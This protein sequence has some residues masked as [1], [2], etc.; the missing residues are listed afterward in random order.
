MLALLLAA[1]ASQEVV[2]G[3]GRG[4]AVRLVVSGRIDLHYLVR[5]AEINEAGA[6][7]NGVPGPSEN[8]DA[9]TGRFT[10][11]ADAELK[12]RVLGVV[13]IENRSYDQG[14]NRPLGA[15]PETDEL[16][17]KQG[18]ID[19]PDFFLDGLRVRVGIQDVS[20]RNRPH[21]EPF[22]L[23]LGEVEGFYG[24]FSTAGARISNS[25]DRDVREAVGLSL[26]WTPYEIL[27]VL[28]FAVVVDENGT[29]TDD[30]IVYGLLASGR[31]AEHSALW[32]M[33]MVVSGGAPDLGRIWTLGSGWNTYAGAGR[34][35]EL[36]AEAYVQG[37]SLVDNVDKRAFAANVGARALFGP[38]WFE[39]AA[40]LRTGDHD[41][42]DARDEAFQSYENENRFLALQ[43]GEF[44]L[45][46]DT[47]LL[48]VRAAVGAGPFD[49]DRHPLRL[50]LDVGRFEADQPVVGGETDWGLEADLEASL[51]WNE[52]LAFRLKLAWLGAS[53]LLERLTADGDDAALLFLA[54]ADLRF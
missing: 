18:F 27:S 7:L 11:R 45:D 32:L 3:D 9:W 31:V 29:S 23:D 22:F 35:L 46:V 10:L 5:P 24:G 16:D 12:D 19:V 40:S 52:S 53:D 17:V 34:W 41:A 15:D 33:A 8:T 47:N 37:G 54:G 44:G 21:D 1:A 4:S 26:L 25:V 30:E 6:S 28:G 50:R 39:A 51:D 20:F 48:L 36:F 42:G 49:L 13:E 43:S 38:L 2:A 14:L